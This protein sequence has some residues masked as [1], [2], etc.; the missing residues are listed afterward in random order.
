MLTR[1]AATVVANHPRAAERVR[2]PLGRPDLNLWG[3]SVQ[4]KLGEG[5]RSSVVCAAATYVLHVC[6][7]VCT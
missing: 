1:G 6:H 4:A 7:G 3:G 5:K 2:R